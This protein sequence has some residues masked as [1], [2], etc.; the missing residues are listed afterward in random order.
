MSL[1]ESHDSGCCSLVELEK[2]LQGPTCGRRPSR[3]GARLGPQT[4][5]SYQHTDASPSSPGEE[6][7]FCFRGVL[8]V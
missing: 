8:E 7:A 6:Y 3:W 5:L 4:L 1:L 2:Q